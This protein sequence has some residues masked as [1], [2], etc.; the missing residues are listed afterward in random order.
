M[1]LNGVHIP[2]VEVAEFCQRFGVGRLALFG[3]ILTP[4]FHADS[5]V[6]VLVEF[7]P[8]RTPSLITFAGMQLELSS[9]VGRKAHLH[10]PSMLPPGARERIGREARLQYA[11]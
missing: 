4:Q 2:E 1:V 3:S 8:G 11:A 5:D 10:T 7:A 6:D 9:I